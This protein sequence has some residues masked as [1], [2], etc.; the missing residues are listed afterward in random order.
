MKFYGL[1]LLL[2]SC[3]SVAQAGLLKELDNK[4]VLVVYGAQAAQEEKDLAKEL[5]L[6]VARGDDNLQQDIYRKD[7]YVIFHYSYYVNY[8][9]IAVGSETSNRLLKLVPRVGQ[10]KFGSKKLQSQQGLYNEHYGL[11]T[12]HKNPLG[13]KGTQLSLGQVHFNSTLIALTGN[14]V[15]GLQKAVKSFIDGSMLGGTLLVSEK[16][17]D[18]RQFFQL[19]RSALI[20]SL[21]DEIPEYEGLK[22]LGW[23]Q[24]RAVD[25][26]AIESMTGQRVKLIYKLH[27]RVPGEELSAL[28]L[29]GTQSRNSVLKVTFK[30]PEAALLAMKKIAGEDLV[31]LGQGHYQLDR[32]G[33]KMFFNLTKT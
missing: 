15:Q 5:S 20:N 19:E 11:V 14:S 30:S 27:Y 7:D 1:L 22:F 21:E 6:I 8:T 9:I 10:S 2:F 17:N 26:T 24:G 16:E 13:L 25:Y 31:E 33:E 28:D 32:N 4:K 12:L 18:Q 29:L 3:L 23:Q